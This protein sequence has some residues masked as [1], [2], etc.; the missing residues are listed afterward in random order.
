MGWVKSV[1][2]AGNEHV[3]WIGVPEEPGIVYICI[4]GK[5]Q[6]QAL[7]MDQFL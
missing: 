1:W 3:S 6:W 5:A 7:H 4:I 2:R